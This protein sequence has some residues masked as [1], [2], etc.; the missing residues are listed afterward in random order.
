MKRGFW[1][2]NISVQAY[3]NAVYVPGVSPW[4]M[5]A[6]LALLFPKLTSQQQKMIM[7]QKLKQMEQVPQKN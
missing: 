6:S 4:S 7:Q 5:R 2:V 1:P 3:G